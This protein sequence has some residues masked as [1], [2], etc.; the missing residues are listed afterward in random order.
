MG[1]IIVSFPVASKATAV[2]R[3]TMISML[4]V[5]IIIIIIIIVI[6]IIIFTGVYADYQGSKHHI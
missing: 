1:R 2:Q 4:I 5:I 6:I 3:K